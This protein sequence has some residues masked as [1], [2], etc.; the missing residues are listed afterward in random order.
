MHRR[1]GKQDP[2]PVDDRNTGT[3]LIDQFPESLSRRAHPP[4]RAAIVAPR[5]GA[6]PPAGGQ[7]GGGSA[8][9][10]A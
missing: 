4:D 10:R 6:M 3:A 1:L 7:D 5:H 9:A 2:G 8:F